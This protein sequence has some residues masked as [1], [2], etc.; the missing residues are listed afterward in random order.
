MSMLRIDININSTMLI[1]IKMINWIFFF[2]GRFEIFDEN[3]EVI[4]M[5]SKAQLF[6]L[7]I[8][9]F[10]LIYKEQCKINVSSKVIYLQ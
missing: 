9:I 2:S 4:K 7:F 5:P 10:Y 8:K 3:N 6:E 1:E